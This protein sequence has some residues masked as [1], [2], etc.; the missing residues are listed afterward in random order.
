[1]SSNI[2]VIE[3]FKEA[4]PDISIVSID[5]P[6]IAVVKGAIYYA[7]NPFSISQ[8]M[9]RYSIGIKVVDNWLDK[10]DNIPGAEKIFV[11][12]DQKFCCLNRFSVF[13]KKYHS[14]N[15]T[16][17]GKQREYDMFTDHCE[18]TFYKSD[19]DGPVY[20]VGQQDEKG[21]SITEE[22]G[23]LKFQ[24]ENFDEKEPTIGIRL[25]LGG[26]YIVAEIEYFKTKKKEEHTFNFEPKKAI[27]KLNSYENTKKEIEVFF[28]K[29]DQSFLE[30]IS[31]IRTDN[32]VRLEEK[33][34][35]K[36]PEYKENCDQLYYLVNG[37][38]IERFKSLDDNNIKNDSVIILDII[39]G[40]C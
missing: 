6:E 37:K 18:I 34:L 25:K 8:R 35:D 30:K 29:T 15:I 33:F 5:E 7:K 3:L 31:G 38:K 24:I 11:E 14:I 26:T 4:L 10:F 39:D 1:M 9:A 27:S 21:Q 22:F 32:F 12:R 19:Y 23:K 13:Y 20:V 36:H 28:T 16:E 2:S 17:K 40:D